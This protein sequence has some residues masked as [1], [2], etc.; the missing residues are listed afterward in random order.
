MNLLY[1]Y[2]IYHIKLWVFNN[3][4]FRYSFKLYSWRWF[5]RFNNDIKRKINFK[6]MEKFYVDK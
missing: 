2:Q 6:E 5:K 4:I 3:W 1:R